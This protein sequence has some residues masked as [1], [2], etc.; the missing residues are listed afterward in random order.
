MR[1]IGLPLGASGLLAFN[2][3]NETLAYAAPGVEVDGGT[4]ARL[5]FR[6]GVRWST[7]FRLREGPTGEPVAVDFLGGNWHVDGPERV[8][9]KPIGPLLPEPDDPLTHHAVFE[10]LGPWDGRAPG[11]GAGTEGEPEGLPAS[12]RVQEGALLK[13]A[14]NRA[15]ARGGGGV[16]L[17]LQPTLLARTVVLAADPAGLPDDPPPG[18]LGAVTPL[19]F[20][21]WFPHGLLGSEP[22]HGGVAPGTGL[23]VRGTV[24]AVGHEA[25]EAAD[26]LPR[27]HPGHGWPEGLGRFL[28]LRVR[29]DRGVVVEVAC[30]HA[31]ATGT[32]AVG[33]AAHALGDLSV[34]VADRP[35]DDGPA[36][37]WWRAAT[38]A[39]WEP[40][41]AIPPTAGARGRR[42]WSVRGSR[43]R[44]TRR[45]RLPRHPVRRRESASGCPLRVPWRA[46]P[47]WS[48]S[49]PRRS[50]CAS[51]PGCCAGGARSP[52]WAGC[53]SRSVWSSRWWAACCC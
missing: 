13:R 11:A 53:S 36:H 38:G 19:R 12:A 20:P 52:R 32:P 26:L 8:L 46:S 24:E 33:A 48:C 23:L 51:T 34:R 21:M 47:G 15:H 49:S 43:G 35:G 1:E 16:L 27:R 5:A 17:P 31:D 50:P 2:S 22:G 29:T 37:G 40:F 25:W 18:P 28:R 44:A 41:A 14:F 4:V 30:H 6:G 7:H 42:S 10:V 39:A 3:I 45:P 9:A